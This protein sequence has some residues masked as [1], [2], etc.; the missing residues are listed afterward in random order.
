LAGLRRLG[1]DV[2]LLPGSPNTILYSLPGRVCVFDPGIGDGRASAIMNALGEIVEDKEYNVDVLLTHGHTDHLAAAEELKYSRLMA[3]KL[4]SA[5]VESLDV[6]FALVYG[7]K[8]SLSLA[9][10]PPVQLKVTDIIK[11]GS[12]V[13]GDVEVIETPGHTPGHISYI[14]GGEVVVAGDALFGERVLARFGVPFAYDL[15]RW[16][17]TLEVFRELAQSGLTIIPGHGPV[18]K[19]QRALKLIDAN[20]AAALRVRDIVLDMLKVR[21]MSVEELTLRVSERL[22]IAELTPRQLALN[23]TT[24]MSVLGWLESEGAIEPIVGDSGVLWRVRV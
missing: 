17:E 1:K 9:S 15:Q 2:Y 5:A 22:G 11:G 23:R 13:C 19:G 20:R 18:V 4:C 8:V 12:K 7:G 3:S 24:I 16:M 21:P 10:M 6:R 14:V